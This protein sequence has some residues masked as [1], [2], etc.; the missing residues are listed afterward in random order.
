MARKES[1]DMSVMINTDLGITIEY[2]NWISNKEH[3]H[4]VFS[5]I[6]AGAYSVDVNGL[7]VVD[8]GA[9]F[10]ETAVYF[11]KQGAN[12][13]FAYEPF[14]SG[15]Y[16]ASNAKTNHCNNIEWVHAAVHSETKT[17]SINPKYKNNGAS[18]LHYGAESGTTLPQMSLDDLTAAHNINGGILKLDCEGA[19][20]PIIHGASLDTLRQYQTILMEVHTAMADPFQISS[21]LEAAGFKVKIKNILKDNRGVELGREFHV[22]GYD[23]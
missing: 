6:E 7:D 16:I 13:V 3:L 11:S 10:G 22:Y 20:G 9:Y 19:E 8:V 17:I 5:E 2:E 1:A 18:R 23:T 15:R 14:Q 21:K 4:E 12:K